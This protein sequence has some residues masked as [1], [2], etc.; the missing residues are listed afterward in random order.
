MKVQVKVNGQFGP[1]LNVPD[2]IKI[3][4][5]TVEVIEGRHTH[6]V[7]MTWA[8]MPLDDTPHQYRTNFKAT[9]SRE[10]I[11]RLDRHA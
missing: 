8:E 7:N 3:E 1:I 4:D 10:I 2:D 5:V 11:N 9:G 6:A